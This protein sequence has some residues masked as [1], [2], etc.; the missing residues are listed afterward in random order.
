MNCGNYRGLSIGDTIG[1]LYAKILGNRLK[2]WMDVDNSQ[3]GGQEA[4]GCIEH[5]LALRLIFD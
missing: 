3:A 5:I 1:K 4:R 2:Q